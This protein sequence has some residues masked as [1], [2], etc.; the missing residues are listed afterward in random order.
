MLTVTPKQAGT[1][2]GRFTGSTE[3]LGAASGTYIQLFKLLDST[4]YA[5]LGH[6]FSKLSFTRNADNPYGK[7]SV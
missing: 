7:S 1:K 3:R 4:F 2:G 5:T 6:I